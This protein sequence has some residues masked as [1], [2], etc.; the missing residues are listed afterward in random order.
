MRCLHLVLL[1]TLMLGT[2][3]GEELADAFGISGRGV[4]GSGCP[5][6]PISSPPAGNTAAGCFSLFLEGFRFSLI[7]GPSRYVLDAE[8]HRTH[9]P[10]KKQYRSHPNGKGQNSRINTLLV[11]KLLFTFDIISP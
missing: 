3:S 1:G 4:I 5:N 6:F 2:D 9:K 7:L 10:S 8:Y 11:E